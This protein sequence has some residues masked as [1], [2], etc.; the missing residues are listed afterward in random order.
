MM[1]RK[2]ILLFLILLG[3]GLF[4]S[5]YPVWSFSLRIADKI[6]WLK[7]VRPGD[8][9]QLGYKHSIVLSDVWESFVFDPEYRIVLTE[10]RFQGQGGGLPH[11]LSPGEHLMREGRWFH[12]TGMKRVVPSIYWRVQKDWHNRFRFKE[13][14]EINIS[15]QV[16]DGLIH[17]QV[18]EIYFFRWCQYLLHKTAGKNIRRENREKSLWAKN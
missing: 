12:I 11:N 14:P 13:E 18:Q 10:T 9:F 8:T 16:G 5:L 3:G 7:L 4:V 17:I 2:G 6:L 1:M 15:A